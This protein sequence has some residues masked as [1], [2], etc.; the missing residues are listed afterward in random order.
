[1]VG[2]WVLNMILQYFSKI[3]FSICLILFLSVFKDSSHVLADKIIINSGKSVIGFGSCNDQ[4]YSQKFWDVIKSYNPDVFIMT[5]DNVYPKSSG[6]NLDELEYAYNSLKKSSHFKD[7][8]N[9]IPLIAIWDDHDFGLNHGDEDHAFKI[10]S[11]KLFLDFF[12]IDEDDDRNIHDG[13]YK[14]CILFYKNKKLQILILDTRFFK[15]KF[16]VTDEWGQKGKERYIPDVDENKTILGQE[17]WLWLKDKM[18]KKVD[19]RVI[20]SSFQVLAADHGWDKWGNFPLE[21]KRLYT[22]INDS[23]A[24]KTII[25]SGDRHIGGIYSRNFHDVQLLEITSSSLNKPLHFLVNENDYHQVGDIV[26][27]AN[28][29]LIKIDWTSGDVIMELRSTRPSS[30]SSVIKAVLDY[31]FKL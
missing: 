12:E 6:S 29:G 23:K 10:R 16:L 11:K 5:G 21:Q 18:K 28:F 31:K 26:T 3:L 30:T 13:L 14:E 15:S 25:I 2:V 22:Q 17:Q 1:M 4:A 24:V 8:K 7:F 19:L 9:Q 20:V 27:Q